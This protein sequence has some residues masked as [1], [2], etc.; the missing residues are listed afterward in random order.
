[1]ATLGQKQSPRSLASTNEL[2][3]LHNRHQLK[4]ECFGTAEESHPPIP[5]DQ[6]GNHMFSFRNSAPGQAKWPTA[7]GAFSKPKGKLS[8][9]EGTE[10]PNV[11]NRNAFESPISTRQYQGENI[12]TGL[13]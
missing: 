2:P 12:A 4:G 11:I 13:D 1:M 9:V 5:Y 7:S 10:L 6:F 8:A 3:E